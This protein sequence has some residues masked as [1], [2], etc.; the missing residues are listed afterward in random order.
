MSSGGGGGQ[1]GQNAEGNRA[2]DTWKVKK[3]I[4]SLQQA[5]GYVTRALVDRSVGPRHIY[6]ACQ[7]G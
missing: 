6:K 3:L 5:K 1:Q 4:K 7:I 2:V